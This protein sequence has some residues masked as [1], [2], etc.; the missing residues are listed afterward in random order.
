MVGRHRSRSSGVLS[1]VTSRRGRRKI[2]AVEIVDRTKGG[3][4]RPLIHA[5]RSAAAPALCGAPP[6]NPWSNSRIAVSCPG[7][8]EEIERRVCEGQSCPGQPAFRRGPT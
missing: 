6:F 8:V 1:T 2:V 7:C 3:T 5:R 4:Y